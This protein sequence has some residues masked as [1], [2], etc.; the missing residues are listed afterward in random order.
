M[1]SRSKNNAYSTEC[2]DDI[3]ITKDEFNTQKYSTPLT[4][5]EQEE[6][7]DEIYFICKALYEICNH[8][9]EK[10]DE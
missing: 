3:K 6:K 1:K 9:N 7:L 10:D 4:D 8:L 5:E 2:F